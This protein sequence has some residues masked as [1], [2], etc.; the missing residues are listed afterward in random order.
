M[1]QNDLLDESQLH[2]FVSGR[3]CESHLI[4]KYYNL[5]HKK[6]GFVTDDVILNFSKTFRHFELLKTF[7]FNSKARAGEHN[8]FC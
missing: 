2:R 7:F 4:Y 1:D 5:A 8:K 3:L 6:E